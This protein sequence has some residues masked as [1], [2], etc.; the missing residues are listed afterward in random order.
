MFFVGGVADTDGREQK[1]NPGHLLSHRAN[2]GSDSA[3]GWLGS[4]QKKSRWPCWGPTAQSELSD[5]GGLLQQRH[6]LHLD[7]L[8]RGEPVEID[9]ATHLGT[10]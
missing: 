4:G 8:T 7:E 5:D 2:A 10:G 3:R 1:E 9:T 6:L